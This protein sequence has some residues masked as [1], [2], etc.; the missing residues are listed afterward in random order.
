MMYHISVMAVPEIAVLVPTLGSQARAASL[1]RALATILSQER[2]RARPIVVFNGPQIDKSLLDEIGRLPDVRI[3][4]LPDAN[5]PAAL[6]EARRLVESDWLAALDDDDELLPSAL[7]RRVAILEARPECAAVVTNGIRRG[8]HGDELHLRPDDA[9][10]NAPMQAMLVKNWM[11]AGCWLC[12]SDALPESV[13]ARM[14]RYLENTYLALALAGSVRIAFDLGEPTLIHNL[15]TRNST[16][17][18]ADYRLGQEAA[19]RRILEL[20]LPPEVRRE[21]ER[22]LGAACWSAAAMHA[23][24]GELSVAWRLVLRSLAYPCRRHAVRNAV[25]TVAI[26]PRAMLR[27]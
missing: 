22:R 5:L 8:R 3:S 12:G 25:R 20:D 15:D 1:R 16:S 9:I 27:R 18:S 26:L 10:E 13:F 7:A 24:R 14:P 17:A 19:L 4:A 2:V 6:C 23:Q 11:L 21:Y